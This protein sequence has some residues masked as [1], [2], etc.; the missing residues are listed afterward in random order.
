VLTGEG[1]DELFA[2]YSYIHGPEFADPEALHGE[3]VH[4]L[5]QLHPL[6]LQCCDRTTMYRVASVSRTRRPG[7]RRGRRAT[8][9][10]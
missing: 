8:R 3:L 10:G 5:E 9:L 7:C 6:N 1:A 2:G 4:S